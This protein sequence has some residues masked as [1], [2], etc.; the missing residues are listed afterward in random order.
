MGCCCPK[1][2]DSFLSPSLLFHRHPHLVL[3]PVV[4]IGLLHLQFHLANPCDESARRR[5][6]CLHIALGKHRSLLSIVTRAPVLLLLLACI[7]NESHCGSA[8]SDCD[9]DVLQSNLAVP[10]P[11][12]PT[13]PDDDEWALS[14][15]SGR[16]WKDL[17]A[18][19]T[20]NLLPVPQAGAKVSE[21][22][23]RGGRTLLRWVPKHLWVS[24]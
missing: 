3:Q 8:L 19:L 5:S 13:P 20:L 7:S 1:P 23:K 17:F 6:Q 2:T 12:H 16:E 24:H 15:E 14:R 10:F 22:G 11:I 18:Y 4:G 21:A 9:R